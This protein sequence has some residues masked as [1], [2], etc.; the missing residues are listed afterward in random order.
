[1][2]KTGLFVLPAMLAMGFTAGAQ[3]APAKPWLKIPI[4]HCMISSRLNLKKS[5][6]RMG[7]TIFLQEDH[8]LPFVNGSILIRG[9]SR[10]EPADKVGLVSLYGETWRLSGTQANAGDKLDDVLA[11]KAASIGNRRWLGDDQ[12]SLVQLQAGLR[13]GLRAFS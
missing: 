6:S 1:M 4:P 11:L 10:D 9:G 8:E 2:K 13:S 12:P 5:C 3:E 7:L